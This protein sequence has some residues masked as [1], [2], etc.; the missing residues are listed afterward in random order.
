[1]PK[2][3]DFH[4]TLKLPPEVV[5]QTAAA[6]KAGQP[7][8]LGVKPLQMFYNKDGAVFCYVEA[9]NEEAVH[10]YHAAAGVSVEGR[11]VEVETAT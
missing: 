2:Y 9:P 7:D 8:Q 5:R 11:I 3:I 10:K 6:I 1:M 4:P